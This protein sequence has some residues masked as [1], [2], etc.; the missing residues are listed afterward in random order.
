VKRTNVYLDEEQARLLR[1]LAVEE[2]RSFTDIVREAL[3]DYLAQR[4]L[5]STSR[6]AGPRRLIPA[7]K[8]RSR[9]TDA[10]QRVRASR[11]AD[12]SSDE[13][14]S[15]ITAARAEVRRERIKRRQSVRG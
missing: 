10:V 5:P 4:G 2:G 11:P 14:D 9:L 15:E 13:I 3:N 7:D 12:L 8:W 1:H 6:V